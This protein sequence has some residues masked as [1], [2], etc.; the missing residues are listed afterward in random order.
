M[1]NPATDEYYMELSDLDFLNSVIGRHWLAELAAQPLDQHNQLQWATRL[2]QEFSAETTHALLETTLL[3]QKAH[4]KFSRADQMF[5][6]RHGLEMSSAETIATYRARR[7]AQLN[8]TSIADLCCGIGG[9]AITLS[10][11][12]DVTGFDHDPL[13]VAMA[14][15]NSAVYGNS[16]RFTGITTDV[17][18]QSPTNVAAVFFDP[19]RRDEYG[20]RI[21]SVHRYRPP[22]TV[23]DRW[24][25][26]TPHIGVKISPGVDYAELPDSAETEFISVNGEVREAVLWFG[27]LHTGATHR[28]TLLTTTGHTIDQIA[29][30]IAQ[31]GADVAVTSPRAWLLEPD[32]A[33]IRAHLVQTLAAQLNATQLDATIAYL[34]ADRPI[35]TP[36]ARSFAVEDWFPFQLKRLRHY[37]REHNVGQVT[38]KKRGSP[39]DTDVLHRQLRL[40]GDQKRTLFLTRVDGEP[41]VIIGRDQTAIAA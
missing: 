29:T 18:E 4:T 39:L 7:Y 33:V 22:L 10:A 3:R 15:H 1:T 35:T 16:Q 9:D 38:I 30:L 27:G 37:L 23:I 5:F 28:A 17:T 21:Y 11:G 14:Q 20:K 32:G 25:A 19:G 24:Q 12:I 26:M 31:P 6:T 13:H 8:V 40:Q 36:F 34:T 41:V 2:R